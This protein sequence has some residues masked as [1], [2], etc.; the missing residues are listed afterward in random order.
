MHFSYNIICFSFSGDSQ[1]SLHGGI[2]LLH[3]VGVLSCL[4][5][6]AILI[7]LLGSVVKILLAL[8]N[9]QVTTLMSAGKS[10]FW[11]SVL[12]IH[13]H[14]VPIGLYVFPGILTSILVKILIHRVASHFVRRIN[15]ASWRFR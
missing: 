7:H 8:T 9:T 2:L 15:V 13:L 11:L 3:D 1:A 10:G 6:F 12:L 5:G 4:L 14:T